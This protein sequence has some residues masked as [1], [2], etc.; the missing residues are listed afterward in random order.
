MKSWPSPEE[1]RVG[2]PS[3]LGDACGGLHRCRVGAIPLLK[4]FNMTE[5]NSTGMDRRLL[6]QAGGA[7]I[8]AMALSDNG[9]AAAGKSGWEEQ[10]MR[11][12]QIC[13][14]DDDPQRYD[15]SFWMDF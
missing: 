8:G 6:L 7:A 4:E 14:T 2:R 5:Q 9:A 15:Q 12:V 10:P 13:A 3:P 11:W 1:L